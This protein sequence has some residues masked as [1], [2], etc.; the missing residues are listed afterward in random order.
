MESTKGHGQKRTDLLVP[1]NDT[2]VLVRFE[3]K[4]MV[5]T[6][7]KSEWVRRV[8]EAL[9]KGEPHTFAKESYTAVAARHTLPSPVEA[10]VVVQ[11]R[12][13][14]KFKVAAHGET[15]AKIVRLCA[16][17]IG[18]A[19]SITEEEQHGKPVARG[20]L[21]GHAPSGKSKTKMGM[22]VVA[23]ADEAKTLVSA[24]GSIADDRLKSRPPSAESPGAEEKDDGPAVTGAD[25]RQAIGQTCTVIY[26]EGGIK[27][28]ITGR[29]TDAEAIANKIIIGRPTLHAPKGSKYQIEGNLRR[30]YNERSTDIGPPDER[31]V[32]TRDDTKERTFSAF[33]DNL[34]TVKAAAEAQCREG[35]VYTMVIGERIV[36]AG[37]RKQR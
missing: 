13:D 6:G 22:K 28:R 30:A 1:K 4:R 29:K 8:G 9:A 18:E 26:L 34:G 2:D 35:T 27:A 23:L 7:R 12:S 17:A 21:K 3:G 19:A 33:G 11:R 14:G 15:A 20:V 24:D 5:A 31:G 37:T 25:A 32:R 36:A 16:E 10:E